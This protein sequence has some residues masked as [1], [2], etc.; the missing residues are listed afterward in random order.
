MVY[1]RSEFKG[2]EGCNGGKFGAWFLFQF[3]PLFS[4]SYV[5]V[6]D[7]Q[8]VTVDWYWFS[9]FL[10]LDLCRDVCELVAALCTSDL[11]DL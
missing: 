8:K 4:L 1:P 2:F 10:L 11:D 9:G 7:G 5:V 3:Q 6:L